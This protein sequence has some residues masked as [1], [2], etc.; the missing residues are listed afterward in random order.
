MTLHNQLRV[1][2]VLKHKKAL[3]KDEIIEMGRL[4][5]LV[6]QHEPPASYDN[7]LDRAGI[8]PET[9]ERLIAKANRVSMRASFE[10]DPEVC[11][12]WF[13]VLDGVEA[14]S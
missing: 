5:M 10:I 14:R 1:I 12:R 9:A 2:D 8:E 11:E 6:Q 7:I 13:G 4:L 3:L